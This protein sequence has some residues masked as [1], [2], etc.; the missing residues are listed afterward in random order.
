M[1]SLIWEHVFNLIRLLEMSL[2]IQRTD[3]WLQILAIKQFK[4][5]CLAK[6]LL[7]RWRAS[8][9]FMTHFGALFQEYRSTNIELTFCVA[10]TIKIPAEIATSRTAH[11][12]ALHSMALTSIGWSILHGFKRFTT[13]KECR[14]CFY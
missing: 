8:G 6:V 14:V 13:R 11:Q 10:A 3:Q 5:Q 9:F 4:V 12:Y 1:N 2:R 7:H